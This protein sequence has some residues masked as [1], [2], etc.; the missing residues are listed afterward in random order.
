MAKQTLGF[1]NDKLIY[2]K[3]YSKS[4]G[5]AYDPYELKNPI[6]LVWEKYLEDYRASAPEGMKSATQTAKDLWAWLPTEKAFMT[7]AFQ[8]M[9]IAT[10]FAF[11]VLLTAT[12]N[13]I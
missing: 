13:I 4:K 11:F 8:G 12:R 6:Y 10:I 1:K 7:S 3:I 9:T 5:E 2:M